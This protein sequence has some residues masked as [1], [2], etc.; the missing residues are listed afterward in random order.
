MPAHDARAQQGDNA[1]APQAE[2]DDS[3]K[4]KSLRQLRKEQQEAEE[5]FYDAFNSV[6]SDD[7]FDISCKNRK[8]LGSR[9]RE[10]ACQAKFLW[11]YEED[12]ARISARAISSSGVSGMPADQTARMEEKQT[13]L[14]NEMSSLIAEVPVV[15]QAFAELARA[16]R[17][18]EAKDAER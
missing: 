18:Y 5:D 12:F 2:E 13:Q 10:R 17:H 16:K 1:A 3:W 14:R 6:N 8:P 9:R 4:R 11:E 15:K 7:E